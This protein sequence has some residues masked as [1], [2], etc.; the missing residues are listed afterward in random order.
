MLDDDFIII[1]NSDCYVLLVCISYCWVWNKAIELNWIELN[2]H[3]MW[4]ILTIIK[5]IT[6]KFLSLDLQHNIWSKMY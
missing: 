5:C 2:T 6:S 1:W 4:A 3:T